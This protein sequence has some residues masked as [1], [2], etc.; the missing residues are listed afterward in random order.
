MNRLSDIQQKFGTSILESFTKK[1]SSKKKKEIVNDSNNF[2]DAFNVVAEYILNNHYTTSLIADKKLG[3]MTRYICSL[4][5]DI[6][7][8]K[9]NLEFEY[10]TNDFVDTEY[11]TLNASGIYELHLIRKD[12]TNLKILCL[13]DADD[14]SV[15]EKGLCQECVG[16]CPL[17]FKKDLTPLQRTR[18]AVALSSKNLKESFVG[19]THRKKSS[20]ISRKS[21]EPFDIFKIVGDYIVANSFENTYDDEWEEG[22]FDCYV[23]DWE[24]C[25]IIRKNLR[26]EFMDEIGQV[27]LDGIGPYKLRLL[28]SDGEYKSISC[29]FSPLESDARKKHIDTDRLGENNDTDFMEDLTNEERLKIA[30]FLGCFSEVHESFT[31]KTTRKKSSSLT[32]EANNE[33]FQ[34]NDFDQMGEYLE[35]FLEETCQAEKL[36]DVGHES[37]KAYRGYSSKSSEESRESFETLNRHKLIKFIQGRNKIFFYVIKN[38]EGHYEHIYIFLPIQVKN[39][40]SYLQL[41]IDACYDYKDADQLIYKR[42]IELFSARFIT[43]FDSNIAITDLCNDGY[44]KIYPMM[45]KTLT[46]AELRKMKVNFTSMKKLNSMIEKIFLNPQK[47][48]KIYE[49]NYNDIVTR[50]YNNLWSDIGLLIKE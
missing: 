4:K 50:D 20:D 1:T 18:I 26:F 31:K 22:E 40:P 43:G 36:N 45:R 11:V 30:K 16:Y 48:T 5:E 24:N 14:N 47:L 44:F 29:F 39:R 33:M 46:D 13:C 2:F 37:W 41:M 12:D 17:D 38:Y 8:F 6:P 27:S 49:D 19:K 21:N 28:V 15:K 3:E 23:K 35:K 10:Y 42:Q 9:R 7:L 25:D 34:I 32:D